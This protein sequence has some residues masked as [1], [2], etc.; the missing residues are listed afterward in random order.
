MTV[1]QYV[2]L[3]VNFYSS[4][5]GTYIVYI[6][7]KTII[8]PTHGPKCVGMSHLYWILNNEYNVIKYVNVM[9]FKRH[10]PIFFSVENNIFFL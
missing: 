4:A 1:K 10:R 7:Y 2:Q 9:L 3:L 5:T 8:A 6:L